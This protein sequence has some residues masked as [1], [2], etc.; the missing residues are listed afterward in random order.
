[1]HVAMSNDN[2]PITQNPIILDPRPL[3]KRVE[4][5]S[6]RS[7]PDNNVYKFDNW[8][9]FISDSAWIRFRTSLRPSNLRSLP[10]YSEVSTQFTFACGFNPVVTSPTVND[11]IP[12]P[13]TLLET[14]IILRQG[15]SPTSLHG[16]R[17]E[18]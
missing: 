14:D 12:G 2:N 5:G 9:E 13:S 4:L 17:G 8:C 10:S 7:A 16:T 15:D 6:M 18:A 11:R 3:S 1:M